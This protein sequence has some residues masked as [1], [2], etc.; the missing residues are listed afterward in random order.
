MN[1]P[2][3]F[4]SLP[5][6]IGLAAACLLGVFAVAGRSLAPHLSTLEWLLRCI[7]AGAALGAVALVAV[8]AK[9]QFNQW[10]LRA[11][12]TDPQ[13]LWFNNEPRG[14]ARQRAAKPPTGTQ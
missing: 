9:L 6:R 13:W 12:G 7:G 4:G 11:G 14:L 1:V 8:V 5:A 2:H 3:W 10:V